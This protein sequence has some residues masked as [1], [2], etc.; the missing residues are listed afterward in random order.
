M[1]DYTPSQT[2]GDKDA[3]LADDPDKLVLGTEL[4]VDWGALQTA[5]ATKYD[6]GNLAT[7]VQAEA[8]SSNSV[9]M[10][11]LRVAQLLSDSGGSKAGIVNDLITLADPGA[12]RLI[13]WDDS[14]NST[15]F[16]SLGNS[17]T[18]TDTTLS[19]S[20]ASVD[21]DALTNF[22]AN[23]H[24]NH[25]SVTITMGSGLKYST[26]GTNIAASATAELDIDG[27]TEETTINLDL[28]FLAFYDASASG[29][30]KVK[31]DAL[32]GTALGDGK[33]YRSSNVAMSAGVAQTIVFNT[34]HYDALE[35][36][37]FNLTT[38]QY[39]AGSA[40]ARV[41][42]AVMVQIDTIKDD[43]TLIVRIQ[44]QGVDQAINTNYNAGNVAA[45]T[46]RTMT[47]S[48]TLN[49]SAS[50]V[51]RVRVEKNTSSDN[52]IGGIANTMISIVELG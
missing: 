28:D 4:D 48:T 22:V 51:V 24:I 36:G 17:L 20:A 42:I 33:W 8:G 30:R 21:H 25:T 6:S 39:T 12:D 45:S 31:L 40:G 47:L 44:V 23:E 9:L 3:L 5:I 46:N 27:L 52:I 50:D 18:I 13:F 19:V 29:I 32:T 15:V 49:L 35:L 16:L 10:T 26:G 7:Q 1:T 38:G 2:Y 11:P 34:A 14:V 37:S 43:E 41:Q